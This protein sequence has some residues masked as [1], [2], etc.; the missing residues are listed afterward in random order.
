MSHHLKKHVVSFPVE[1]ELNDPRL[2][3]DELAVNVEGRRDS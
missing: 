1:H 2:R 3:R